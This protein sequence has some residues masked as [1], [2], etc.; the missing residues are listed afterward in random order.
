MNKNKASLLWGLTLALC[1]PF[2]APCRAETMVIDGPVVLSDLTG[3]DTLIVGDKVFSNFTYA[4]TGDMPLADYVNVIPIQDCDG[5]FGIRFQGGFIDLPGKSASDALIT[6][7]VTPS[8]GMLIHDVHLAAN[9]D[10]FGGDG[11]AG[12]SETFLPDFQFSL[13]VF[14]DGTTQQL[15]DWA[16]LPELVGPGQTIETLQVQKDILLLSSNGPAATI[17]FVDQTFSQVPEPASALLLLVALCGIRLYR[18]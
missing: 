6:F 16:D 15:I 18:R 3:G 7:S 12:I 14:D 9:V 8:A 17:S 10:L 1:V 13:N 4:A 11:F 5:N 2:A